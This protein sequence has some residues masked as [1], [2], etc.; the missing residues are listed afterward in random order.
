MSLTRGSLWKKWDLHVH[1]PCSIVQGYGG[2]NEETWTKYIEDL[3]NLPPEFK[4]LGIN[5]YLFVDGY[6]RLLLEKKAGRLSNIEL[7]LPVIE[8]RLDKFAGTEDKLSK[9]NFHIIFSDE[10]APQVIRQQ[11]L[12]AM[13]KAY[14]ISRG[15]DGKV[16]EWSGVV[17]RE[18]LI[19]LG[20]QI[21]KNTEESKQKDLPGPLKCGFDNLCFNLEQ[22]RSVLDRS[23]FKGKTLTAVGR[24]EWSDIRWSGQSILEKKDIIEGCDCV[25]TASRNAE[26]WK[27]CQERLSSSKVNNRLIHCSDAH[28]FSTASQQERVG[29]SL[30]WIKADPSFAGLRHAIH[31]YPERVFV[32]A[33]PP[34]IKLVNENQTKFID[35]I[36]IRK[37]DGAN[38]KE[39]WFDQSIPLN[40]DLVAIIGNKGAGKSALSDILGLL[41]NSYEQ[42]FFSFLNTNKFRNKRDNKAKHFA[43]KIN[44][45]S[46]TETK[47]NLDDDCDPARVQTVKYL[48]QNFLDELC[49]EIPGPDVTRFE[50][51]L[52]NVIFSH[53]SESDRLG[54]SSLDELIAQK[55]AQV[56]QK[57][58]SLRADITTINSKICDLEAKLEPA[59]RRS[60]LNKLEALELELEAHERSKP[61]EIQPPSK[62]Q[63]AKVEKQLSELHFEKEEILEAINFVQNQNN[64]IAH[65]IDSAESAFQQ[66]ENFQDIYN[67]LKADLSSTLGSLSI[68]VESIVS[69]SVDLEPIRKLLADARLEKAFYDTLLNE[70]FEFYTPEYETEDIQYLEEQT[71]ITLPESPEPEHWQ[72]HLEDSDASISSDQ[73]DCAY[74]MS[75][76]YQLQ[77]LEKQIESHKGKLDKDSR[78]YQD[79]LEGLKNW[80][81]RKKQIIG[82]DTSANSIEFYKK[83]LKALDDLPNDLANSRKL[84]MEKCRDIHTTITALAEGYKRLFQPVQQFIDSHDFAK[85]RLR[86]S[87]DVTFS[88]SALEAMFF[89]H[90]SKGSAGSFYGAQEGTELLASTEAAVDFSDADQLAEF[91]EHILDLLNRDRRKSEGTPVSLSSQLRKGITVASFYDF[92]FSLEYIR[93]SYSLKLDS[94]ELIVL[95]PGERC[96]LLLVF[97]LLV[98]KNRS[99][100]IIDQ[101]EENLDNQTLFEFLVPCIRKAKSQRQIIIV[102]HNPNLAVVCDAEQVI[103]ASLNKKDDCELVYES[104]ALEDPAINRRVVDILE[105]TRPAFDDRDTKYQ[106]RY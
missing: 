98:D 54:C 73:E 31:E 53:V 56:N 80:E 72:D 30:T 52:R 25:F 9:V 87:F 1:T 19:D 92:L 63:S 43:A 13:T 62:S 59:Y 12:G 5:D 6:E 93:P 74:L 78:V 66:V 32:G 79:Y 68:D 60:I 34:K 7:L 24:K 85:D 61:K 84:R 64:T 21:I 16:I 91:L 38:L 47:C 76:H 45:C 17:T 105:G 88:T 58:T 95:S 26:D 102:T 4:V 14:A 51:E 70:H 20:N 101:P 29:A 11:F 42:R 37:E 41:G 8:I 40:T 100:L 10:I 86:L 23:Y 104:G 67:S 83:R 27:R 28:F 77:E 90:I 96:L 97:F 22:V 15:L 71:P 103:Y 55:T 48:P 44:W 57:L 99:P 35:S 2:N 75:Y 50:S 33:I 82:S 81:D 36:E 69:L 39:K 94:K 65:R 18:S 89:N 46:K 3:E 49:N 106:V